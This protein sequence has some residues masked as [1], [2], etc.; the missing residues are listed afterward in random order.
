MGFPGGT[1]VENLPAN[2]G[3]MGSG[4]GPEDP[5]CRGATKPV[6]HN[7]WAC[8]LEPTSHNYWAHEPQ[9]LKPM[10]LDPTLHSKRSH[11]NEKPA[12]RDKE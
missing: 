2:A 6:C 12:H 8:V 10:C 11:R 5:T 1:V 4:P 3:D 9:L 7:Y